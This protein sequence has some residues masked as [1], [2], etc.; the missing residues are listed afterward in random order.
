MLLLSVTNSPLIVSLSIEDDLH[1]CVLCCGCSRHPHHHPHSDTMMEPTDPYHHHHHVFSSPRSSILFHHVLKKKRCKF[2]C[3]DQ[4]CWCLKKKKKKGGRWSFVASS[5]LDNLR[6]LW[7]GN[8][9]WNA[10]QYLLTPLWKQQ[11]GNWENNW[12]FHHSSN[13]EH[14]IVFNVWR[15]SCTPVCVCP[16]LSFK[17]RR[18]THT[19]QNP[20][21]CLNEPRHILLL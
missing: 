14:F 6:M 12:L 9:N 21:S 1:Q 18:S 20:S 7:W 17:P 15:Q 4:S 3:M 13:T 19:P 2:L 11:K 10:A 8:E 16:K 5:V